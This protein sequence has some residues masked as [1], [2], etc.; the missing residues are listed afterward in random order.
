MPVAVIRLIAGAVLVASLS[1]AGAPGRP[2][3]RT[4]GAAPA[5][6][7]IESTDRQVVSVSATAGAA[8]NQAGRPAGRP[9]SLADWPKGPLY[10]FQQ[11]LNAV[12]V[13]TFYALLAVAYVLV[14]GTAGRI[15]LAFGATAMWSAYLTVGG[16]SIVVAASTLTIGPTLVLAVVLAV[17]GTCAL[18]FAAQHIVVRPLRTHASLAILVATLGLSIV[19][20]EVMR[21]ASHSRDIWLLPILNRPILLVGAKDFPVQI[22]QMQVVIVVGAA[23]LASGLLLLIHRHSFGRAWRACAQ[24]LHMA[25]LCGVNVDRILVLTFLLSSA[26][27]AASGAIIALYYGGVTFHMGIVLGLKALLAAVIGGLHSVGGALLGALALGFLESLWSAYFDLE[28][29]DVVVFA[30]LASLMIWRPNG[31]LT[32]RVRND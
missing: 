18:G 29:R 23:L 4:A 26:Y 8:A 14:Y 5:Q 1:A 19:L 7:R 21:I 10:L 24:D 2:E 22:T 27:A 20:E 16:I 3:A 30:V 31:L 28:D 13:S 11:I 32:P 17:A 6:S 15:N 12:K 25:A 9:P